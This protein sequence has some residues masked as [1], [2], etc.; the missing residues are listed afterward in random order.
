MKGLIKLSNVPIPALWATQLGTTAGVAYLM[1]KYYKKHPIYTDASVDRFLRRRVALNYLHDDPKRRE[2]GMNKIEA[3]ANR[4]YD[5]KYRARLEKQQ[6]LGRSILTGMA[7]GAP[8]TFG[9]SLLM[10]KLTHR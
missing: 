2:K 4:M 5:P 6:R 8:I 1:D 3:M 7:V 10:R 9:A